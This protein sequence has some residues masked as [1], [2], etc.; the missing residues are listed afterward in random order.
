MRG[1]GTLAVT[2]ALDTFNQ[3]LEFN[4]SGTAEANNSITINAAST[5]ANYPDLQVVNLGVQPPI[6]NSGTNLTVQWQDTNGGNGLTLTAWYDHLT[7]SNASLGVMLLDTVVYYD[8]NVLGPLTNGTARN[9]SASF[10]L[11]NGANG[12][13]TLQVTVTA[14]NFNNIF[15]YNPA[16]T[17]ESNNAT[18]IA[19]I[20]GI[21]A[22]PDLQVAGLSVQPSLLGS[23]TNLTVAWQDTNSGT[24]PALASWYDHL[25]ISNASLRVTLLDTTVYYDR[26]VLG[27]LTNGTA[28]ARAYNFALPYS[29]NG[30]GGLVFTVTV[31]YFNNIFEYNPS[32]TAENNNTA[33]ITRPSTLTPLPDLVITSLT[34][35]NTALT[36]QIISAR[37]RLTNQGL[38]PANGDM[39]QQVYLS[40]TPV[41]GS[42]ILSA[43]ADYNGTLGVGQFLNQS[44]TLLTPAVPGTYWLIAQADA[45]NNVL[46]LSENNN[47]FISP[48]P[49]SVQAAYTASIVADIHA[50]LANAPIPMHGHAFLGGSGLPAAFV[51]VTIHIQVRGTDRTVTVLTAADGSFTNLF[52]PLP[53]EAGV[54]QISAAL[55]AVTSPPAQ[56]SFTLIGMSVALVSL[57]DMTEGT[58]VTNSTTLNNLSDI[59]LT[60]LTVTVK[61]NQPNLVVSA[62]ISTNTLAGFANA[63]LN[64]TINAL[65]AS[66]F[67]SPVI[68]HVTSAEG[69]TADLT[70][71]V[72]VEALRPNLVVSPPSLHGAMQRGA[73][74]PVAFTVANQGGVATGPLQISAPSVPWLS[75]AS[76]SQLPPLAPG[77]NTVVTILLTPAAALPLGTYNGTLVV[78]STN[79]AAQVPFSF[80][81]VS[82]ALGNMLVSADDE[83]T[84]F[85]PGSPH[86]TNALVVVSDALTG[87]TV[88]TNLTGVDGTA[89]FTNLTEAYYQVNVTASRHSSFR[90]SALV[91]AGMT[92]NVAAFLVRQTVTYSFTVTPTT[93]PDQ[94]TFQINSTFEA[95]VPVPVVTIEPA[96]LDL[97]KYPGTQFQVLYTIAN[98]GLIDAESVKLEFP[99]ASWVQMTALVTNLGKLRA[100]SSYTVPVLVTRLGP[101]PAGKG[102]SPDAASGTCSVTAQM[103]WN[104]LCG[105]NVV[106]KSTAYYAFD[107]TGCNL[108]DL[109]QQVYHLVPDNPGGGGPG[110]GGLITSQDYFDYLNQFQ[111]VTDFEPPPG[112]HFE[113]NATSP[114]V[115]PTPKNY[116]APDG[117]TSVCAKV[118]IRLDQK[119]VLTRDAF[120]A[121]LEINND[122]TNVLQNVQASLRI[123]DANGN[124][125]STNFGVSAPVL[126]GLTAVDGTGNLPGTTVGTAT[127]TL[128]PTLDAAPSSGMA[129]YLVGGTLSYTQDGT[130]VTVPLAAAPIQVFPQPE[131]VVRYF[132]DRNVFADDPFTPQIEPSIPYSLAVQ[133]N[134]VGHGAAKALT[135]SSGKPQI[136]DNVKGLLINFNILGTQLE[137]QPVAPA[138]SVN[139]GGIDPGS[140]KIARWLFTSSLQGSFTNFSASFAQVDQFGNPRLSLIRGVEI[141]ELTHI[142]DAGGVFEDARPDFLVNDV[143][144]PDFLPDALYLSDGSIRPV[145]AVTNATITGLLGGTNL[146]ITVAATLPV[147]W[148]YLQ[149]GDPGP[150]LYQLT[151][152][153]RADHSEIPLGTNVWTTDRNFIGG[154]TVPIHTNLVHLL[155]YNSTG[156]YTLVY[157]PVVTNVVDTIPPTS[158]VTALPASSPPNFT[159]QWSGTDNAGGS[160]VAFFNV[161]VSTNGGSFAPWITNTVLS[162]AQYNGAPNNTYAFFS[163][164]TDIA[165]NLEAAHLTADAQ[166]STTAPTNAPPVITPILTQSVTAGD[167]FNLTPTATDAN[168][169]TILTWSLL[170][171]APAGAL[172]STLTGH[173][174]WQTGVGDGGTTN[175][176]VLVVADN[177]SPSL[178]ATQAFNVVVTRLNHAPTIAPIAP[179]LSVNEE[180]T[181]SLQLSATDSDLPQQTLTWQLGA[182]PPSGL[183]LDPATGLLTWTPTQAQALTTNLVTVI[184]RDNGTPVLSDSKTFSL[185]VNAVNHAPVLAAVS[186][187]FASVLLPL[188]LTNTATDSDKPAQLL[189]FTLDPG[190]PA[191]AVIRTN[192]V[193]NW[194]PSRSQ[195]GSTNTITVRVTDNGYPALS[196]TKT[197]TVVVGN[198]LEV[199][200][201]STILLAGQTG[202]V[203][204]AMNSTT[205]VTNV[206][207]TINVAQPGLTNFTLPAPI[208]PLG[209][210]TLQ[211]ISPTAFQANFASLGGQTLLGAQTLSTLNFQARSD[212]PSTFIALH[213]SSVSVNQPNGIALSRTLG[214]DG[215]VV[216]INTAPLLEALISGGQFQLT[217]FAPPGPSYTVQSTPGLL[218]PVLWS[219]LL[220][221]AVGAN[222]FQIIPV[223]A[224]NPSTFFRVMVP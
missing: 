151:H 4:A 26:N 50:A 104:Y 202:A 150:D 118:A 96:S 63:S 91:A 177:G 38:L 166:T 64:F 209:L 182:T 78:A 34:S 10:T 183:N 69:A 140:N 76:A 162:A 75:L 61:T 29:S 77:S 107:S 143:P 145:V 121:T 53:N 193:F 54:Y 35:T 60:G 200:M 133:V 41:A 102:L 40:S 203:S 108:V 37:L 101:S 45:N 129:I 136:V 66:V 74:T 58:S 218:P 36:S 73:Q 171:G 21:A 80:I 98:H 191:G 179:Q 192:G 135:I 158:T 165:G 168:A 153:F 205:P 164:A 25:T 161:Y 201:G 15:E 170:P 144:D 174:T 11:P 55:P 95:Q 148:S 47:Y 44:V 223:P 131:L 196:D 152:V 84:Y 59:P 197:F 173:L 103:L 138:L 8:P 1:V 12:A 83:Y 178:S 17:A 214:D 32:G 199:I 224:T 207:V 222:L 23:G 31:D 19:A 160:G 124:L 181:L 27:P 169:G 111:I 16:G 147:G 157:A 163:R 216:F 67:Q 211:Q 88:A 156:S 123:T 79:A 20:S 127:W 206:N 46:E 186:N 105:P 172:L 100:N 97:S 190:A 30:A 109:Y 7:I 2:V 119:G 149:F 65:N 175:G 155:D 114:K 132:H 86:V 18:T 14:D 81:A 159:V 120:K 28:R 99:S 217:I 146:A 187:Q 39:V 213:I 51:P 185:V 70:I 52:Q 219:P 115:A 57:V 130:P 42:G 141:H 92:T 184:V 139:F 122:I 189:A 43:I 198:Y 167:L 56:D 154:S 94:Y 90:Q 87:S 82:S 106:D 113:C 5:I 116:L 180:A 134:N 3:L 210:A 48:T 204:I 176:F 22:Y 195:A 49:I 221:S 62:S 212:A 117:T 6:I 220:T 71:L 125:V 215:R 128:I 85:A 188:T 68:L 137:N 93:V 13:G 110:G 89:M 9:R 24:A 142:V 112:Y 72:R 208:P 126:S 194:L 33:S